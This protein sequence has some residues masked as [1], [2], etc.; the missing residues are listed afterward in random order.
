MSRSSSSVAFGSGLHRTGSKLR[1]ILVR[2]PR[3]TQS[4]RPPAIAPRRPTSKPLPGEQPRKRGLL[5]TSS[6]PLEQ[7]RRTSRCLSGLFGSGNSTPYREASRGAE[8]H[9]GERRPIASCVPERSVGSVQI[10]ATCF[11]TTSCDYAQRVI[12]V[13]HWLPRAPRK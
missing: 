5:R 12:R 10:H 7:Q 6:A 9:P 2:L 8:Y 11:H 3:G 4:R 1:R 13:A